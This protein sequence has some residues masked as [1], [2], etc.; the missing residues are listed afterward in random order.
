MRPLKHFEFPLLLF[1]GLCRIS[2]SYS[3]MVWHFLF[4]SYNIFVISSF[5]P[6]LP[7]R[8]SVSASLLS[9]I[10]VSVSCSCT[11]LP[12]WAHICGSCVFISLLHFPFFLIP[13]HSNTCW[14]QRPAWLPSSFSLLRHISYSFC[15][16]DRLHPIT[17]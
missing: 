5:S 10:G 2:R 6:V 11:V 17:C 12:C 16:S 15:H 3:V 8:P 9:S 14:V 4:F 7:L 1:N 13:S